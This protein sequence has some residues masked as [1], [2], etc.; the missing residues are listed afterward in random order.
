MD[1]LELGAL[2]E[3]H[4]VRLLKERGAVILERNYHCRFGEIDIIA[5]EGPFLL[6]IEVK[7]R[8]EGGMEE[9]FEAITPAKQKKIVLTAGAYIVEHHTA[10]QPRFDAAAVY[11]RDGR[12]VGEK[13]LPNAFGAG[14]H[15]VE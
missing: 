11:T 4:I 8:K 3:E 5:Q 15:G 9:P 12:I 14:A 2:G 13:Y 1:S 6:F 10:L 7:T